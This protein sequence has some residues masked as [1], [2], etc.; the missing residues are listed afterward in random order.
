METVTSWGCLPGCPV[1]ALGAQSGVL[2]PGVLPSSQY[3]KEGRDNSSMFAG[4]GVFSH[5]GYEAD[6]GGASR[7]F[8][9]FSGGENP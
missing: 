1:A 7:F 5:K 6:A 2:K 9:Q 3:T 4:R 8:K